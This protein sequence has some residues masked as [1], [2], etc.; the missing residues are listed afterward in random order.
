MILLEPELAPGKTLLK[1]H[2]AHTSLMITAS[3]RKKS[4]N[5]SA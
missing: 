3:L 5:V 4:H 1:K 2:Y